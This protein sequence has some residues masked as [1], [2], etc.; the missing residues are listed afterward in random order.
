MPI[1]RVVPGFSEALKLMSIGST[2]EICIPSELA[3]GPQ[4]PAPIGNNSTLVFTITL[5]NITKAPAPQTESRSLQQL[6]P[7][8]LQQLQ[9]QGLEIEAEESA[10]EEV[11]KPLPEP[12]DTPL[13]APAEPAPA[14]AEPAPA[15]AESTGF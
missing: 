9:Q 5:N 6:P 3:Y 4:G 7:E 13:P 15:P 2:W 10:A 12:T 8:L 14:P 11:G 1:D